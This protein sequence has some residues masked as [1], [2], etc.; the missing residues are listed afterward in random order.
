M[1]DH[2]QLLASIGERRIDR[3]SFIA[4]GAALLAAAGLGRVPDAFGAA[5]RSE[6][7][8]LFYYNWADYVNP[9]TYPAF[10]KATTVKV[11]MDYF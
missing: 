6:A 3:K 1:S 5:G 2:E 8:E 10:T 4:G 7:S 9:K 11:Q